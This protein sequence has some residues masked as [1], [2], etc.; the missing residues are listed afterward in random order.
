MKFNH[1]TWVKSLVILGILVLMILTALMNWESIQHR[2]MPADMWP[3]GKFC[4]LRDKPHTD[5]SESNKK[6]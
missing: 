1:D 5:T 3:I 6:E 2:F 4:N